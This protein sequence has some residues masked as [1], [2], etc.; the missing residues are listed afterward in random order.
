MLGALYLSLTYYREP[1]KA[2]PHLERAF[3][4]HPDNQEIAFDLATA[5]ALSGQD[6]KALSLIEKFRFERS[7]HCRNFR[8][9]WENPRFHAAATEKWGSRE[10]LHDGPRGS[11][12][13]LGGLFRYCILPAPMNEYVEEEVRKSVPVELAK[14]TKRNRREMASAIGRGNL[15]SVRSLGRL[16]DDEGNREYL[17][18]EIED[19]GSVRLPLTDYERKVI[20]MTFAGFYT[21]AAIFNFEYKRQLGIVP[22]AVALLKRGPHGLE[23][24]V[25]L[26][27][28]ERKTVTPIEGGRRWPLP[29]GAARSSLRRAWSG[30]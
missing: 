3:E 23:A 15:L 7:Y 24:A 11:T 30:R 8:P 14:I 9:F 21:A 20:D 5:Y 17:T 6:E 25:V 18:L 4:I 1:E 28:D 22:E 12:A 10:Y 29:S 13:Y 27:T 16:S 19:G 26:S 2:L